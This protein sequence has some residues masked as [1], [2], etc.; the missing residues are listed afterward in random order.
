MHNT[1]SQCGSQW[2][3]PMLS[4]L[5]F[6]MPAAVTTAKPW[7]SVWLSK[8][9]VCINTDNHL[10]II[11]KCQV[12]LISRSCFRYQVV[13]NLTSDC[14]IWPWHWIFCWNYVILTQFL[15]ETWT[16][17]RST[18]H[19]SLTSISSLRKW[20][21]SCI[22]LSFLHFSLNQQLRACISF[23]LSLHLFC[24]VQIAEKCVIISTFR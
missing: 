15:L 14:Q 4:Y 12:S 2:A 5:L 24:F 18:R 13:H 11:S 23:H 10:P 8:H 19:R 6:P 9:D 22:T 3:K 1:A 20:I 21:I 16:R 17:L 7:L